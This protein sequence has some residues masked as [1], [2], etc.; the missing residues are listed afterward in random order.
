MRDR[1]RA[2][3]GT[4]AV[5]L[6]LVILAWAGPRLAPY[7]PSEQPDPAAA[8]LLP[9]GTTRDV[10]R[11][12][13]GRTLVLADLHHRADLEGNALLVGRRLGRPIA[14]RESDVAAV[15]RRT[16]RLGTDRFGRDVLS[17]LLA[18]AR[19]SLSI[20]GVAAALALALGFAAAVVGGASGIGLR[21]GI[22]WVTRGLL[23]IP[24]LFLLLGLVVV[25]HPGPLGLALVLALTSWMPTSRLVAGEIRSGEDGDVALAARASGATR[26]RILLRHLVPAALPA[27]LTDT[28]LRAGDFILLEAALSFLGAGIQPPA[29]SW[30]SMVA[31]STDV[32]AS[33][34]WLSLFPGLAILTAVAA[35]SFWADGLRDRLD[36]A[37]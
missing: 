22:E 2:F 17:R 30:G 15:E 8:A 37:V 7:P 35:L 3:A 9:P 36:P 11:L 13:D 5:P 29:P 4:S 1:R 33:A 6:A 18:G 31:E 25:L 24:R 16:H 26:A 23:S 12:E 27:A 28:A 19:P 34:W 14:I 10:V 32:L 20:A 21:R